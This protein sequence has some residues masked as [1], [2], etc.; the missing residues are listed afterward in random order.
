MPDTPFNDLFLFC[1]GVFLN[2]CFYERYYFILTR[3]PDNHPNILRVA[4]I[5]AVICQIS[6]IF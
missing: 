5:Q 4:V 3:L 2:V 6:D 1:S